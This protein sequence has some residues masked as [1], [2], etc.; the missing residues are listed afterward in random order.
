MKIEFHYSDGDEESV[1]LSDY[2]AQQELIQFL[3]GFSDCGKRQWM[4]RVKN[5][6]YP[7]PL[8]DSHY[9]WAAK[10]RE[11]SLET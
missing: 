3:N 4:S 11:T 5:K 7:N 10:L 6:D 9:N 2:K 1:V 8:Q